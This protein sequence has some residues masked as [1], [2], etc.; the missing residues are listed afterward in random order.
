MSNF[1]IVQNYADFPEISFD[2][3]KDSLLPD[4]NTKYLLGLPAKGF[5]KL[6]PWRGHW[7]ETLDNGCAEWQF[8]AREWQTASGT[9]GGDVEPRDGTTIPRDL[10]GPSACSVSCLPSHPL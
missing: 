2:E 3:Y 6:T 8:S 9:P 4:E 1:S 7:C 10:H 5:R